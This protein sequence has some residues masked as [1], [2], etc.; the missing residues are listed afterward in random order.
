M[1]NRF[2]YL[3]K[4]VFVA[5]CLAVGCS[6]SGAMGCGSSSSPDGPPT[7]D[8]DLLGIYQISL[9]Q[10]DQEGCDQ[11]T[12]LANPGRLVLYSTTATAGSNEAV[13]AGQLCS[14]LDDCRAR[15]SR[16]PTLAIYSFFEGSDTAGWKGWGIANEAMAGDECLFEVQEH[17]LTSPGDRTITIDTRQVEVQFAATVPEGSTRGTCTYRNAIA[18]INDDSPCK[19][20]FLLQATFESGL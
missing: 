15:A 20:L 11:L 17:S 8:S 4:T 18:A 10:S 1:M 12:D 3:A 7:V 19:A 2:T 6:S 16:F 5:T 13:L 14:S 9:Y